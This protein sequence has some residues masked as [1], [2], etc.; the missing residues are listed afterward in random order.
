MATAAAGRAA[1]LRE[2]RCVETSRCVGTVSQSRRTE[3]RHQAARRARGG[4]AG[5]VARGTR[6]AA[7][8]AVLHGALL[9]RVSLPGAGLLGAV[10]LLG[11]VLLGS[12]I[13]SRA[14]AGDWPDF[15]GPGGEGSAAGC[16][17]PAEWNLEKNVRWKVPIPGKGWSSPIVRGDRIFLT[18][19]VPADGDPPT[20]QSLRVLCLDLGT[21]ATRWDHEI[22]SKSMGPEAKLHTKNSHA[23]PSPIADE[24]H[25][26]VHFG[27]DG[28]ACLDFDGKVVWANDRLRYN[29][30]HG[31][32]GSPIFSGPRLVFHAD[33]VVEPFI[34][35][36][37]R[38]SGTVAWKTIR[39]ETQTPRFSFCTPL[40][41]VAEG[42]R[43][44]ISPASHVVV[45]YDPVTGEELWRVT[46]P[47]KWS[48]VPRPVFS[49]GL[50]FVCTGYDGPAELLAIRPT[51]S[52]DVTG[53]HV[54]WKTDD[55]V[56]HNPSPLVVGDEIYLMADNGIASCRD[57]ATG[58]LHW[59]QRIGGNFSASPVHAAGRIH[60]ISET[61][62]ATI[63]AAGREWRELASCD[64]GEAALA[65]PA[66]VDGAVL[67]RTEGH[68]W[69]I[70]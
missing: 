65:S 59:R 70:E 3:S 63:F 49:H 66:F 69:R 67:V 42:R 30:Q 18:T 41:I 14:A 22:F 8:E 20:R 51:G 53:S 32:G 54:V 45:S 43:Q 7:G 68:L 21:G 2:S 25:L 46:Y 60:V 44:I 12:G 17:P 48:V 34:A 9:Q 16:N 27:P 23:S 26:F 6:G 19:A 33:G 5:M 24:Q 31:A 28:T 57:V 50:V 55:N 58:T 10:L 36:L 62:V 61:G 4:A 64:F 35:A 11:V 40:E 37:H 29:P 52:G 38:D 56:P 47:N 39:P 1:N 15:R 13:G